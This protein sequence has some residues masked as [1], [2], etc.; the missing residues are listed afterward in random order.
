MKAVDLRMSKGKVKNFEKAKINVQRN[1]LSSFKTYL[2]GLQ[3]KLAF[4]FTI[5]QNSQHRNPN[6]KKQRKTL[7]FQNN[8]TKFYVNNLRRTSKS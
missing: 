1:D 5:F 3:K 8:Q 2:K 7:N 6:E 4:N